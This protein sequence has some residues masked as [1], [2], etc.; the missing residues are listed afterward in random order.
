MKQGTA[1]GYIK[2]I[3]TEIFNSIKQQNPLPNAEGCYI[4][5]LVYHLSTS[6]VLLL[7]GGITSAAGA[8]CTGASASVSI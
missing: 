4:K 2:N 5:Q 1:T 6:S 8:G 7:A 3:C